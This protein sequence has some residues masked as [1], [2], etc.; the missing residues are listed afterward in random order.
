MSPLAPENW[1]F[2]TVPQKHLN[3]RC[4]FQPRGKTLGGSSAINAMIYIR[5]TPTDY[6]RWQADGATGWGWDDVLP[7]FLKAE[8]N[9]RGA[10]A[11]HGVGGPLRVGDLSW[12]SVWSLRFLE[13]A[14]QLQLPMTDDFNGPSQEGVGFYQVTQRDGRRCSAASAYLKPVSDRPNLRVETNVAVERILFEGKRA[15]GLAYRRDGLSG[16]IATENEIILC[17]GAF[18]SPHLLMLSGI[19]PGDHLRA[20]G[21]SPILDLPDVGRHLQ[22]HLDY[23]VLRAGP[24]KGTVNLC[25]D[26]FV[27]A[28]PQTLRYLLY[29]KGMLTTNIAEAGGFLKTAPDEPEPDIQLHFAPSLIDDHGRRRHWRAGFS[30][31]VCVLRPKSRGHVGLR[32]PQPLAPPL[33]DPNYLEDED[34]LE[35]LVRGARLVLR[36][37]SAPAFA[38]HETHDLYLP[39][40]PATQILIADIRRRA[41]TI[42]HPVGTCRMGPA[43]QSVVSPALKVHG[44]ERLRVIDASVMPRLISGN[45]NAPAIMIAEK[46]ADMIR[47]GH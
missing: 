19:G 33:I 4:G 30:A 21:L 29:R 5:G 26:S 36:L 15:C 40:A 46:A 41:D 12:R 22:D 32:S 37:F 8:D 1:S 25:G 20:H 27:R 23:T 43:G 17:A 42:Y 11:L 14:R 47:T 7:Y 9:S 39:G 6:E 28:I 13:A 3:N 18:K 45:T 16:T 10:S 2:E 34:D 44:I 31:H 24:L 35:R 38:T